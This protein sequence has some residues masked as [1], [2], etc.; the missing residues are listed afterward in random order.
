M[1]MLALGTMKLGTVVVSKET[2]VQ[3]NVIADIADKM[4]CRHQSHFVINA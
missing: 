1:I 4:L 3:E 2:K